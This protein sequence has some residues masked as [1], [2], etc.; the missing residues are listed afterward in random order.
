MPQVHRTQAQLAVYLGRAAREARNRIGLTQEEVAERVGVATE[1]YGRVE[2]GHLLPSVPTLMRLSRALSLD[3]NDLLG[4]TTTRP[5]SWLVPQE[6]PAEDEP[7]ALRRLLRVARRLSPR[8]LTLL[9]ATANALARAQEA[10]PRRA[11]RR[12]RE[13]QEA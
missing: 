13:S 1:V 6:A 11:S 10:R 7:P 3:A 2:R 4:F 8:Q 9:G 5:P 12:P